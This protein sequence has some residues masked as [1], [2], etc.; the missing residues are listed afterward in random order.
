VS[1]RPLRRVTALAAASL[2]AVAAFSASVPAAAADSHRLLVDISDGHGFTAHPHGPLL[3]MNRLAP[4]LSTGA[5]M[6]VRNA[7]KERARLTLSVDD[8]VDDDNGCNRPEGRVDRGCGAGEGELGDQLVIDV[9]SSTS[10]HGRFA[11]VWR[12]LLAQMTK[13]VRA[14]GRMSPSGTRWLRI[15]ATLPSG[16]GNETQTDRVGFDL[17]V[18]LSMAT[19]AE[20]VDVQGTKVGHHSSGPGAVLGGLGNLAP[21]GALLLL[22]LLVGLFLVAGGLALRPA[23]REASLAGAYRTHRH[24]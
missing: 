4:G 7:S 12:G 21:T 14:G 1:S 18:T 15:T 23:S 20:T 9:A 24:V 5:T 22:P 3:D 8:V 16:S 13:G 17:R 6:G 2:L 11:P 19:D 10:K